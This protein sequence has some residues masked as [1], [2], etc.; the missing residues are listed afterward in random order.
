MA[1]ADPNLR[2]KNRI[3]TVLDSLD[4]NNTKK[5]AK[6]CKEL[7]QEFPKSN[8][9]KV[10]FADLPATSDKQFWLPIPP[11]AIF[12]VLLRLARVFYFHPLLLS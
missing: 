9:V 11:R 5:T 12:S 2:V 6:L 10:R 7:E 4:G 1:Q 3:R 8:L